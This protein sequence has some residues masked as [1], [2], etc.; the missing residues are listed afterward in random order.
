MCK[1]IVACEFY[2][3]Y[4]HFNYFEKVESV[5]FLPANPPLGTHKVVKSFLPINF[6]KQ[7]SERHKQFHPKQ[8][9]SSLF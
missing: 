2:I 5:R 8:H 4:L 3:L 9:L 7:V 1:S 6:D